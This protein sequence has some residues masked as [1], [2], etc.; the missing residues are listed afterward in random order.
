[1]F[2]GFP[3]IH[4]YTRAQ[5]LADGYLVDVTSTARSAGVR[6][7]VALT[8]TVWDAY[9]EFEAE[10]GEGQSIEGRLWDVLTMFRFAAAGGGAGNSMLC[11]RLYVA[12]AGGNW[13][14]NE[15]VP[16]RASGFDRLTHR[17][18]TLKA[19][20]GP[21]DAGEPVITIMLPDED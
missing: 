2:E 12:K 21:G 16:P 17:L 11:F 4:A 9:V 6:W 7:P 3:L 10:D 14:P 18:V 20:A 8:R 13:Q 15:Q 19:V 5:A 1:M